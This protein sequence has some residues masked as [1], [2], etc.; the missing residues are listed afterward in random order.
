M[1]KFI[2]ITAPKPF[3]VHGDTTS[4]GTRWQKWRQGFD[5]YLVAAGI[6]NA[7]QKKALLLHCGGEDLRELFSTLP[8]PINAEDDDYIKVCTALNSYFLPKK[9]KRYERHVFKMSAQKETETV[10][11]YITR[12]RSLAKTCEFVDNDDEIVDQVIEKCTSRKLR[13]RLLKEPDLDLAKLS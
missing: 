10:S 9:N 13:K 3:N 1:A 7:I 4:L 2:D 12:L 8:D 6:T 11:Q 5:L